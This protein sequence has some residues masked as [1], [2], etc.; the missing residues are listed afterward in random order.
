MTGFGGACLFSD[1]RTQGALVCDAISS[2][3]VNKLGCGERNLKDL[4]RP[5]D[6]LDGGL[7]ALWQEDMPLYDVVDEILQV[8]TQLDCYHGTYCGCN[9]TIHVCICVCLCI[10]LM[11]GVLEMCRRC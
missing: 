11:R 10:F 5:Y 6:W 3:A 7:R 9:V 2:D 1:C 8:R 4:D